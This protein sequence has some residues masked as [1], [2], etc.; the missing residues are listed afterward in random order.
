MVEIVTEI[1]TEIETVIE[2]EIDRDRDSGSGSGDDR[3]G[4]CGWRVMRQDIMRRVTASLPRV[5]LDFTVT[6]IL[7]RQYR[8]SP[9]VCMS[10]PCKL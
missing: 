9:T 8:N 6:T 7:L 4:K 10:I 5:H 3:V 2:T 1:E